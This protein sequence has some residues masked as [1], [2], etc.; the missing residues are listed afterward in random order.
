MLVQVYQSIL[1]AKP[2]DGDSQFAIALIYLQQKKDDEAMEGFKELVNKAQ[3]DAPACYYIGR[4]E[5]K[6]ENFNQALVWFD[7]VT[8]GA[9]RL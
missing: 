6:K 1:D 2:E 7:K 5:Y 9:Y 3:W 4:I 8:K